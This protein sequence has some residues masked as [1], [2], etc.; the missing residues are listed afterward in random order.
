[1]LLLGGRLSDV[2][3]RKAVGIPLVGASTLAY[4]GFY[5]ASGWLIWPLALAGA[6]SARR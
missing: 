5:L 1:M 6:C 2:A 3:S 4:A